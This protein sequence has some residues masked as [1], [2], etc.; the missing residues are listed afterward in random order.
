MKISMSTKK[1]KSD[2][3]ND[4]IEQQALKEIET[5]AELAPN[6]RTRKEAEKLIERIEGESA[7]VQQQEFEVVE[8]VLD[9]TKKAIQRTTNEAKREIPRY[10]KA[11]GQLQEETIQ[12]TKELGYQC[13]EFQRET[14]SLIPQL[15][16]RYLSFWMPW[17]SPTVVTEYYSR[18]VDNFVDNAVSAANLMNN[19]ATVNLESVQRLADD[20]KEYWR[21][22]VQNTKAFSKSLQD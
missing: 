7:T 5:I 9:D 16:Q 6:E 8:S 10:T 20:N 13:I 2:D 3:I 12:T 1:S 22:G 18:I 15:Q 11:M 21:V 4:K 19:L 17:M 14:A